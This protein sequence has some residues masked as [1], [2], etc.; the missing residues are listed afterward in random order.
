MKGFTMLKNPLHVDIV[1]RSAILKDHERINTGEK[2]FACKY[3]EK[4]FTSSSNLA[5]HQRGK[6]FCSSIM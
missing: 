3:C 5:Q 4:K 1:T 6:T 2:L